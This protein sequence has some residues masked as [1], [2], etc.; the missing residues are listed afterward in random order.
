MFAGTRTAHHFQIPQVR[1]LADLLAS[2]EE[3]N[4]AIPKA[5]K[6]FY[7]VRSAIVHGPSDD[8]RRRLMQERRQAFRI[9]FNLAQQ[10][11]YKLIFESNP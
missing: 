8:H 2:D 5:A 4:A 10:A 3:H 7:D 1:Q 6:K 9:G 11:Y